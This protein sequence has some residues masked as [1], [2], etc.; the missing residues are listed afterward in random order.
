M[1]ELGF[2]VGFDEGF[3]LAPVPLVVADFFATPAD[4]QDALQG[5]HLAQ[6]L[7]ELHD[8]LFPL[9]L[10][11]APGQHVVDGEREHREIAP[12]RVL[13]EVIAGA[14]AHGVHGD[15]FAAAAGDDDAGHAVGLREQVEPA[16]IAQFEI[17]EDDVEG[18]SGEHFGGFPARGGRVYFIGQ[19]AITDKSDHGLPVDFVVIHEQ[20]P[21]GILGHLNH[22]FT[23]RVHS[24]TS[25]DQWCGPHLRSP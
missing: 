15:L 16:S 5:L 21:D 1:G 19:L 25:T 8:Q 11:L 3:D 2:R 13:D 10:G 7:L 4:G 12:V 18:L 9:P 14:Q 24:A 22:S 17:E 6:G 23:R 20:D